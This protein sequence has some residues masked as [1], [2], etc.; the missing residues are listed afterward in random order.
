MLLMEKNAHFWWL[1]KALRKKFKQD[2]KVWTKND[3][4]ACIASRLLQFLFSWMY[5]VYMK[6]KTSNYGEIYFPRKIHI[7]ILRW[8]LHLGILIIFEVLFSERRIEMQRSK[9]LV[10]FSRRRPLRGKM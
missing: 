2:N 7:L 3:I 6:G 9:E 4:L 5:G 10:P 1:S 8:W